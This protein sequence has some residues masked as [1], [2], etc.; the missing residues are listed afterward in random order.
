MVTRAQY[1]VTMM[2]AYGID[3]DKNPEDNFADGGNTWYTGYL[4][5]ARRLGISAGIGNNLFAPDKIITR[6]EMFTMLYN[7][8]NVIGKL[9]SG[10]SGKT[11]SDFSDAGDIETWA[12]DA[13]QLLVET[14]MVKGDGNR[15]LPSDNATRAQVVQ[16]FYNLLSE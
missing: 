8:L 4:A 3:P 7:A 11:L 16:M 15:L 9:P 10:T 14:G 5:S 13:V 6:Q 12:K 1:L 2:R